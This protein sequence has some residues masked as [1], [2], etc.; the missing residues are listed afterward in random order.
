MAAGGTAVALFSMC[1]D[2]GAIIGPVVAGLLADRFSY[3]VA[4]GVGAGLLVAAALNALRMPN[5]EVSP[6]TGQTAR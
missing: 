6:M 5:R 3:G 2:L 1:A 4:F